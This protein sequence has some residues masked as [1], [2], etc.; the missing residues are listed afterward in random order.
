MTDG[1]K[2]SMAEKTKKTTKK[3]KRK[4]ATSKVLELVTEEAPAPLPVVAP[5]KPA[6]RVEPRHAK[7]GVCNKLKQI[8][9]TD[10][11]ENWREPGHPDH[12]FREVCED[13]HP[14][15]VL[16]EQCSIL[17]YAA[18]RVAFRK[19]E[20]MDAHAIEN[21]VHVAWRAFWVAFDHKF[22]IKMA[23][24]LK[25]KHPWLKGERL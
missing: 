11:D 3:R 8:V 9:L 25:V 10:C 19:K 17:V 1:E 21:A 16:R 15:Y 23:R 6:A 22:L 4:G 2:S 24:T 5:L 13:C 7:C 14:D 20:D 12:L 18:M